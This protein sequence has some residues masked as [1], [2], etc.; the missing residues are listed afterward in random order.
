MKIEATCTV[1]VSIEDISVNSIELAALQGAK[2][3][4][5]KLFLALLGVVEKTLSKDRTCE[6]GGRLE[7]KGRVPREVIFVS[8]GANWCKQLK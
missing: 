6:C 7:S 2:E 1:T 4:G 3:A 5:K 8:D